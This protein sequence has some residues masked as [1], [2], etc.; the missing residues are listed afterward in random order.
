MIW[1]IISFKSKKE[2]D[3][4]CNVEE[5]LLLQSLQQDFSAPTW[6]LITLSNSSFRESIELC[7]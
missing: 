3:S 2:I 5:H 6:W 4:L 7:P 1:V